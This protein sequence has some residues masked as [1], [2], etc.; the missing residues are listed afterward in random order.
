MAA[1]VIDTT[2]SVLFYRQRQ[3]WAFQPF[4]SNSPTAWQSSAL[5]PGATLDPDT[6]RITASVT[7][8][9]VYVFSLIASNGSGSS[10][11]VVFT[12]GIEPGSNITPSGI[13]EVFVDLTTRLV[14]LNKGSFVAADASKQELFSVKRGDD[15]VMHVVFLRG[16]VAADL[17]ISTLKITGKQFDGEEVVISGDEWQKTGEGEDAAYRLYVQIASDAVDSA[18]SDVEKDTSTEFIALTELE[19]TETNSYTPQVGP[20]HL[21]ASSLTFGTKIVRDLTADVAV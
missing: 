18:L 1:P 3:T 2:Q 19:W 21:R 20:P 5:P 10:D 16:G 8:P 15:L 9:G 4:A 6:G 17:N 12:C 7:L 14:S 11:A 13:L